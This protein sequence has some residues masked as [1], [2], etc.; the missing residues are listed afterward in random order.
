M[1]NQGNFR[2]LVNGLNDILGSSASQDGNH[3]GAATN[4]VTPTLATSPQSA[5]QITHWPSNFPSTYTFYPTISDPHMNPYND[6]SNFQ[7][8]YHPPHYIPN[9]QQQIF[10]FPSLNSTEIIPEQNGAAGNLATNL[11]ERPLPPLP[12]NSPPHHPPPPLHPRRPPP[13]PPPPRNQQIPPPPPLPPQQP[14]PIPPPIPIPPPAPPPTIPTA[15]PTYTFLPPQPFYIQPTA[16][17][18]QNYQYYNNY[19]QQPFPHNQQPFFP[20][21]HTN[22]PSV[23]TAFPQTSHIPELKTRADW[24]AW[25]L[26]V[27]NVLTSRL[28][29]TH[30]CDPP[31]PHVPQDP[32]NTP[33]YPPILPQNPTP[34]QY[35][36]WITWYKKDA[37]VYGVITAR[38]SRQILGMVPVQN[39]PMTGTRCTAREAFHSLRRRYG[40]GNLQYAILEHKRLST[41]PCISLSAIPTFIQN[42]MNLVQ[43]LRS[44][45]GYPLSYAT[46][47]VDI[48][49]MLPSQFSEMRRKVITDLRN[50]TLFSNITFDDLLS[51]ILD[52]ANGMQLNR[53]LTNPSRNPKTSPK[54]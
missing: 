18:M 49:N 28:L 29:N 44:T 12:M 9:N 45:E 26:G 35:H 23:D 46:L 16:P 54:P 53:E 40:G 39:D 37:I 20:F 41:T 7:M 32:F 25:Q 1:S 13:P 51:D 21:I 5:P 22:Q 50:P 11:S 34:Q 10:P 2:N 24:G 47:S 15:P 38:L 52:Q 36:D 30:I 48:T 3:N 42:W 14:A 17:P 6:P 31:A 43:T 8:Q 19:N 4:Q 33:S 27:L